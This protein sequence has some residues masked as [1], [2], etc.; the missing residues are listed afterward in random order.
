MHN[1]YDASK[2]ALGVDGNAPA[3]KTTYHRKLEQKALKT[4]AEGAK[5][6]VVDITLQ[7]FD[8]NGLLL[9]D[10]VCKAPM[11]IAPSKA[12]VE[13]RADVMQ[14]IFCKVQVTDA[15]KRRYVRGAGGDN[16]GKDGDSPD[17]SSTSGP[18]S[19]PRKARR[20]S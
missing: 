17:A 20:T 14:W 15:P 8:F 10:V 2:E 12:M 19:G 7:G 16:D 4:L 9:Q 11:N 13:M 5:S 6:S 18:S 3:D 1:M